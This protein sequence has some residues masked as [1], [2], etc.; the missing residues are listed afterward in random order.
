M[1]AG[2]LY[3]SAGC[4][5]PGYQSTT[6]SADDSHL[7]RTNPADLSPGAAVR[8]FMESR[9]EKLTRKPCADSF[10]LD[11]RCLRVRG[12]HRSDPALRRGAEL[13]IGTSVW[14]DRISDRSYL[15]PGDL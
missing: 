1:G 3:G 9:S 2:T 7:S 8:S 11:R 12:N 6:F 5:W 10:A 13:V 15:C 14:G 4:C